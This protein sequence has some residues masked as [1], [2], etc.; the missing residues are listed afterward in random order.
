MW[1]RITLWALCRKAVSKLE[2]VEAEGGLPPTVDVVAAAVDAV[3]ATDALPVTRTRKGVEVTEDVRPALRRLA[4]TGLPGGGVHLDLEVATRPRATRPA[5]VLGALHLCGAPQLEERQVVRTHQW[6]EREG[7]RLE[8]LDAD[9]RPPAALAPL[10]GAGA[11][12][13]PAPEARAS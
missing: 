13:S 12:G 6:I 2:L 4:A 5:D 11:A 3:W 1:A 10:V 9:P 8:P 7:A